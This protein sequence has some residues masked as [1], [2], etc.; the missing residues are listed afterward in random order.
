[1]SL[2]SS[3]ESWD[4]KA[5]RYSENA[6]EPDTFHFNRV[7]R[8]FD[9][10]ETL[11]DRQGKTARMFVKR[12]LNIK[13]HKMGNTI[14]WMKR[15]GEVIVR[16]SDCRFVLHDTKRHSDRENWNNQSN[17]LHTRAEHGSP[18]SLADIICSLVDSEWTISFR[19]KPAR[20][21]PLLAIIPSNNFVNSHR[22]LLLHRW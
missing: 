2:K 12:W 17:R 1:M 21:A 5:E 7:Q 13:A 11:V 8:C 14:K 19:S 4:Y 15:F 20:Y 10:I 3:Q 18:L 22:L 9:C 16:V 6:E